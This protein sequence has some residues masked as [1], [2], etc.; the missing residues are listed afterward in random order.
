[1]PRYV[2]L[3]RG[4]N[5][6]KAK[7]IAMADL[8]TVL[9]E[10]GYTDVKTLLNSGNVV[11]TTTAAKGRSAAAAIQERVAAD[12]GVSARVTALSSEEVDRISAENT[13][14]PKAADASRLLVAV[15]SGAPALEK[16][17]PLA[18]RKWAPD[19]L[20]VGSRAAY[21]WCAEGILKSA[22]MVAV[23]KATGGEITSRNWSTFQKLRAL[24][25]E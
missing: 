2:A 14:A 21:L 5:V 3:F 7:R 12:L 9:E 22:L 10:L 11:F 20:A 24:C 1:V 8:R 4:I 15:P 18:A 19:E 6:G 25:E 16:L 23:E 13:L 17:M